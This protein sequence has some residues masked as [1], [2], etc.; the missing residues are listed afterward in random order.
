M[1][2]I[3]VHVGLEPHTLHH[4]IV[5]NPGTLVEIQLKSKIQGNMRCGNG[6]MI[7]PSTHPQHMNDLKRFVYIRIWSGNGSGNY[8]M[9]VSSLS[10]QPLHHD[11]ICIENWAKIDILGQH[12]L[13]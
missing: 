7:D 2:S 12:V 13:W 4:D 11:I 3:H 1:E 8:S 9:W 6:M 5:F 10:H